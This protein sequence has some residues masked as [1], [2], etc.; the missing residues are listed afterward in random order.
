MISWGGLLEGRSGWGS[1]RLMGSVW[2]GCWVERMVR[3][4]VQHVTGGGREPM[5]WKSA[6]GVSGAL[7]AR[8]LG[9]FGTI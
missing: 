3:T 6:H 9:E 4:E 5:C 1:G 7:R 8:G 2:E